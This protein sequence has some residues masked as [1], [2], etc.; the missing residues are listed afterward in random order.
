MLNCRFLRMISKFGRPMQLLFT[1]V[2][3]VIIGLRER[4][5]SKVAGCNL[6]AFKRSL[7]SCAF[8]FNTRVED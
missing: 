2:C 4:W 7:A 5:R 6:R 1:C 3:C 8:T